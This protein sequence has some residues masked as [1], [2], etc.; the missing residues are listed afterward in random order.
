MITA[1]NLNPALRIVSRTIDQ[2][3][4]EKLAKGGA[5]RVVS[6]HFIGAMRMASEMIRP[7]V[8]QFLDLMLQQK[9]PTIR[10]EEIRIG[11]GS[12]V[13][14]K[15]LFEAQLHRHGEILVLSAYQPG[16]QLYQ[17]NPDQ[18]FRLQAGVVLVVLGSTDAV[19]SL[20]RA[21]SGEASP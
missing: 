6:T 5:D 1:R 12:S 4:A 14:G 11:K 13:L 7:Q 9:D 2:R 19:H 3:S 17:H 16:T 21:I 10:I 18:K 8:V 20:R 15:T